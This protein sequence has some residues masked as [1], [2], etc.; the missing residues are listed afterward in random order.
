VATALGLDVSGDSPTVA[1]ARIL[2]VVANAIRERHGPRP[3]TGKQIEYADALGLD[4]RRDTLRVASA[5]IADE[6]N[7]RNRVALVSMNLKPGDRVVK[8]VAV[9][10]DGERHE[11]TQEFTISSIHSSGRLFFKGG[12]GWGA[13]PTEVE[14]L[15]FHEQAARPSTGGRTRRRVGTGR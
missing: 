14:K 2:D 1:S 8:R 13:W 7:R 10:M 15:H 3:A 5:R 9:D 6:L 4:V 11:L 12:N